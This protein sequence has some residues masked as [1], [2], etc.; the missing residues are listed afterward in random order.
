MYLRHFFNRIS[1]AANDPSA[2]STLD[3]RSIRVEMIIGV[4]IIWLEMSN[5][6]F[7]SAKSDSLIALFNP[8]N[9]L[10]LDHR[11]VLLEK[12]PVMI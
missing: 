5:L 1:K 9:F 12:S 8:D 11:C 3:T 10:P 4:R 7:E 2:A 6:D